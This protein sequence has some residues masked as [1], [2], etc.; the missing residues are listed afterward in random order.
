MPSWLKHKF[1][2]GITQAPVATQPSLSP[3]TP[4]HP[5]RP[6]RILVPLVARSS[7]AEQWSME[8][9]RC[10]G[11][12]M[13]ARLVSRFMLTETTSQTTTWNSAMS[14][15]RAAHNYRLSRLGGPAGRSVELASIWI[16][17]PGS[18]VPRIVTA[19]PG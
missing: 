12:R 15:F 4:Q 16:V 14:G 13:A 17:L 10:S 7:P 18:D 2:S 8:E 1:S 3:Q 5:E 6:T 11:S 19:F 9:G